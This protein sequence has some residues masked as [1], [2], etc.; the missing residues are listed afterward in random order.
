MNSGMSDPR[1]E[2]F[3]GLVHQHQDS[4]YRQLLRTCGKKEDAEDA[5][6]DA[7]LN[8]YRAFGT[9]D[10]PD[11]FRPW[12][13]QIGK[14]VCGRLKKRESIRPLLQMSAEEG[15]GIDPASDDPTPEELAWEG[16][17]KD[18]LLSALDELPAGYREAYEMVELNEMPLKEAA[19]RMNL[20]LPAFKS[21]LHRA[22]AMLRDAVTHTVCG[23]AL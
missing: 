11:S 23:S 10:N 14:R 4:V 2:Q 6:V 1:K 15:G 21:R 17:M 12:L 13:V 3:E 7:L 22:R 5:L 19:E 8:A 9:L 16:Q 20:T 18:C